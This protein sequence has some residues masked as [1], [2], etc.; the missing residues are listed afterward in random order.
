MEK[1][2]FNQDSKSKKKHG[3]KNSDSEDN[4]SDSEDNFSE[5]ENEEVSI[6]VTDSEKE[7]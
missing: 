5:E 1:S 7:D 3:K 6:E 4:Y 2:D